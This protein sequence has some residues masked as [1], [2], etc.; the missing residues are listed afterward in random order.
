M[1]NSAVA[2]DGPALLFVRLEALARTATHT[3][4]SASALKYVTLHLPYTNRYH[5]GWR[6]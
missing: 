1:V 2:L 3:I 5:L 6:H 4:A